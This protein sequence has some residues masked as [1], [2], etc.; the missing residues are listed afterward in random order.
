MPSAKPIRVIDVSKKLNLATTTVILFLKQNCYPVDR[1]HHTPLIPEMLNEIALEFGTGRS[2]TMLSQLIESSKRWENEHR[3]SAASIRQ[4]YQKG[5]ARLKQKQTRAKKVK[6]GRE[7][8]KFRRQEL[9]RKITH[10]SMA[11]R[12]VS[13]TGA[14]IDGRIK[15]DPIQLEIIHRALRLDTD[16]KL[17][18]AKFLQRVSNSVIGR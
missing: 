5:L 4:I 1:S 18:F 12:T 8:A 13:D 15:I 2:L 11:M 17:K 16:H 10:F 3:E 9:E 6:A 14:D 7:K